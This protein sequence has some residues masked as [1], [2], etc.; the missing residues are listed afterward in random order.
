MDKN[1]VFSL[2]EHQR[3]DL[4]ESEAPR[5]RTLGSLCTDCDALAATID[6]LPLGIIL[7]DSDGRVIFT[8]QSAK[9]L[10]A[11]GEGIAQGCDGRL[12]ASRAAESSTL[13]AL[14]DLAV[15]GPLDGDAEP[16]GALQLSRSSTT[17]PLSVVVRPLGH[18]PAPPSA[19]RP[20]A[21]VLCGD[22]DRDPGTP[23][24][25]LARLYGLTPSEAKLTLELLS[26]RTLERAAARLSISM[27]TART[28]LKHVFQKTGTNRQVDLLRLIFRSPIALYL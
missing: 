28:H 15:R 6:V 17:R 26:G 7:V 19:G 27:N 11:H 5:A 12:T 23:R 21:I 9:N 24:D 14:I 16:C 8:N 1:V 25:M 18:H 10:L 20:A 3:Q 22:P 4:F 2:V 13:G